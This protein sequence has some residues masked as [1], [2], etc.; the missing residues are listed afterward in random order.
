MTEAACPLCAKVAG[1]GGLLI[2][3]LATSRVY[4]HEDQFFA[5]YVLV[6]LRRHATEIY[7]L[8]VEERQALIEDVS[9]VAEALARV[10]RP[11]KMNYEL[12]GNQVPHIHWHVIP[13]L[14]GDPEPRWPVWRVRHD[15]APMAPAAADDRIEAIRRALE[16]PA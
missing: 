15:P 5:G 3:D 1:E 7:Q 10:F 8:S 4:L 6:V 12:L 9:R 16:P 14:P 13:R 2:A 11:L